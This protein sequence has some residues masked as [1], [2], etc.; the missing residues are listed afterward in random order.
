MNGWLKRLKKIWAMKLFHRR[1]RRQTYWG[2]RHRKK[3]QGFIHETM[4]FSNKHITDPFNKGLITIKFCRKNHIAYVA[5]NSLIWSQFCSYHYGWVIVIC[6]NL[7]PNWIIQIIITARGNFKR[8]H[9]WLEPFVTRRQW[10]SHLNI[11]PE[12]RFHIYFRTFTHTGQKLQIPTAPP[13]FWSD[14]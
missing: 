5:N 10:P 7:W 12:T 6:A 9:L 11:F 13:A 4:M 8:F 2:N 3:F 14:A 1:F